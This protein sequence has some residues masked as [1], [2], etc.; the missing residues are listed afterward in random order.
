MLRRHAHVTIAVALLASM[1]CHPKDKLPGRIDIQN[2]ATLGSDGGAGALSS[3]PESII[4]DSAGHFLVATPNQASAEPVGI[5]DSTGQ[6]LGRI[7]GIGSGPG[8]YQE[9][10]LL[11]RGA[12]DSIFILDNAQ[13]RMSTLSPALM[14]VRSQSLPTRIQDAALGPNGE[15]IASTPGYRSD[16]SFRP[17]FAFTKDG[18]A[19]RSYGDAAGKCG[20]DCS[21]R[22]ARII[23]PD[24]QG[25]WLVSR[26]FA[27]SVEHWSAD[28]RLL[29]RLNIQSDWFAPYDSLLMPTP[30]RPPQAVI[31]GAW[32]DGAGRLWI[33]GNAPDPDWQEGLGP[34]RPGEGGLRYFPIEHRNRALD[35]IIEVRDTASGAR[36]AFRRLDDAPFLIRAGD[37][38]IGHLYENDAGWVLVDLLRVKFESTGLR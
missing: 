31:T 24:R 36:L 37:Q 27:F 38:M 12:H 21:W 20:P 34:E 19:E 11:L 7:G 3:M 13:R 6:F 35:G 32:L 30:D 2:V 5:Y 14:Y 26:F 17:V 23:I 28:G 22:L 10:A 25:I 15:L 4:R 16:S 1:G 9:P 18:N 8:E 29:R 33:I